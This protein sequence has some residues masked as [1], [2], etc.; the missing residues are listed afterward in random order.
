MASFALCGM[1]LG[2][3]VDP[4][5]K[6]NVQPH[7]RTECEWA[8]APKPNNATIKALVLA[9]AVLKPTRINKTLLSQ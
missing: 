5:V 3:I 1:L 6:T 7:V 8:C 4:D 2:I 9:T